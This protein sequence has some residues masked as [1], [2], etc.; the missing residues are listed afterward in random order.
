MKSKLL[1]M[2]ILSLI[3]KCIECAFTPLLAVGLLTISICGDLLYIYVLVYSSDDN[4]E[5]FLQ[6]LSSP[7]YY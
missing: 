4:Q 7:S 6:F 5:Q 1:L 3:A 2:N